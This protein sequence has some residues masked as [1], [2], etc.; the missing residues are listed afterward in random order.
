MALLTGPQIA[1]EVARGSIVIDPYDPKRL[2][3]NSYD[4][5]LADRLLVYE[6]AWA[7]HCGLD[8]DVQLRR[9]VLAGGV[10][11]AANAP[12]PSLFEPLDMRVE[13]RVRGLTIPPEGLVLWPG[14]LY[15][16]STAEYTET[17]A[18]APMIEGRSSVGR[19]GISIHATAGFGDQ[20]FKG[21]WTLEVEVVHPVRVYAGVRVCQIAYETLVGE[22]KPYAGKYQGQRG[23]KPSGLWR[24]FDRG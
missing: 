15:L 23:P 18:H 22:A 21:D 3:S 19:L 12:A 20:F 1:A 17:H 6:K 8:Q 13:E 16:A 10:Y 24:D 14:V 5:T 7:Y 11:R 2:N 4:L 9:Q